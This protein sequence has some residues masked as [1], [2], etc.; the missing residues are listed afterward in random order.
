MAQ[1]SPV[2]RSRATKSIPVS[3]SIRPFTPEPHRIVLLLVLRVSD[4]VGRN[5]ALEFVTFVSV[6]SSALSE[7]FQNCVN[8]RHLFVF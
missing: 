2:R 5:Q 8:G 3:G 1:K 7:F 6:I 4:K